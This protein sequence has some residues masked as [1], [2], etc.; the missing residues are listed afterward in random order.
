MIQQIEQ[1]I[2]EAIPDAIVKVSDPE[3]DGTHFEAIVVS[4]SF[5]NLSLVKQHQ[6]VM[7]ALKAEFASTVHALNLKTL[8]PTQ[9]EAFQ[10]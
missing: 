1:R 3:N 10:K 2:Q 6:Q 4:A 5:E 9:W 7:N 8:T